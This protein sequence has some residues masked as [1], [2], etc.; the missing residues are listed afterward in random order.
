MKTYR[1]FFSLIL[2]SSIS[3]M[4]NSIQAQSYRGKVYINDM[5]ISS[6]SLASLKQ[7]YN[8]QLQAGKYWYDKKCGAWGMQGG[9]CLGFVP[10]NI[11]I[12][13]SLKARASN[14]NTGVFV[15]GRELHYQDVRA[16]R[17]I[18]VVRQGRFWLDAKGN[19]GYEGYPSS[20]NLLYLSKK[21]GGSSFYRNSY[22]GMGSGSS[23]G[24]SYVMGKD[25]S[26]I[27]DY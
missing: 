7:Y 27:I 25:F 10:A 23:G 22:T 24:T 16:L 18:I 15:N 3:L 5:L 2:F 9:P 11:R 17:K 14:G 12:G 26:V 8:I 21:A 13:G 4:F 1:I 19:G 20:F 6:Q